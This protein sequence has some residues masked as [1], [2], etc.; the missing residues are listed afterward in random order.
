MRDFPIWYRNFLDLNALKGVGIFWQVVM[1]TDG[2]HHPHDL[3]SSR[4]WEGVGDLMLTTKNACF[5]WKSSMFG[6]FFDSPMIYMRDMWGRTW[7]VIRRW[8]TWMCSKKKRWTDVFWSSRNFLE[9]S[10]ILGQIV[11]NCGGWY[12]I[13]ALKLSFSPLKIGLPKRKLIF[14]PLVFRANC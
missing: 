12:E 7:W 4:S 10:V 1:G 2:W 13:H 6:C 11:E 9:C 14:Q 8:V 3:T 5:D